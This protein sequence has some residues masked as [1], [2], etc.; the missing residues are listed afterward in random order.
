MW[1]TAGRRAAE[2]DSARRALRLV[3]LEALAAAGTVDA[4]RGRYD[5]ARQSI[6]HWFIVLHAEVEL[7][8]NSCLSQAQRGALRPLL[9]RKEE[10]LG[11]LERG[12]ASS[13]VSLT[14]AYLTCRKALRGG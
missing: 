13:V 7:G 9:T 4:R 10:L 11:A 2:R 12:E 14:A 8:A 1:M 5:W 6:N 3:Q